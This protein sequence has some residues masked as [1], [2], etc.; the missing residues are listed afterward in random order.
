MENKLWKIQWQNVSYIC[1]WWPKAGVGRVHLLCLTIVATAQWLWASI[2]WKITPD[3]Q[4]TAETNNDSPAK[5]IIPH[6]FLTVSENLIFLHISGFVVQSD[7]VFLFLRIRS[8]LAKLSG[9]VIERI[10][11]ITQGVK[12]VEA[13]WRMTPITRRGNIDDKKQP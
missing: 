7:L 3:K 6:L 12:V 4:G 5:E 10:D 9:S 2:L 11:F 13:A 1:K 8:C